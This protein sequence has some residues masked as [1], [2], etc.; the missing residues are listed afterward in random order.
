MKIYLQSESHK[1]IQ[2]SGQIVQ[3]FRWVRFKWTLV[4]AFDSFC[5]FKVWWWSLSLAELN[6]TKG[7][8]THSSSWVEFCEILFGIIRAL[9]THWKF[10]RETQTRDTFDTFRLN[11]DWIKIAILKGKKTRR[12]CWLIFERGTRTSPFKLDTFINPIKD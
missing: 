7:V 10:S 6:S 11:F 9:G 3:F 4:N 5:L 2:L 1:C 12:V 8:I